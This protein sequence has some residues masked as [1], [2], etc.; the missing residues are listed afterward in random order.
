MDFLKNLLP[1]PAE[2]LVNSIFRDFYPGLFP[3]LDLDQLKNSLITTNNIKIET[4]SLDSTSINDWLLTS[5][6]LEVSSI[7]LKG[8]LFTFPRM[9]LT[10]KITLEI[11]VI[12]IVLKFKSKNYVFKSIEKPKENFL[13]QGINKALD[14]YGMLVKNINVVLIEEETNTLYFIKM[15]NIEYHNK[16]NS[17]NS[18]YCAYK[19]KIIE[20]K[21]NHPLNKNYLFFVGNHLTIESIIVEEIQLDDKSLLENRDQDLLTILE[22]SS[23]TEYI[24][25]KLK[26]KTIFESNYLL[27]LIKFLPECILNFDFQTNLVNLRV[28]YYFENKVKAYGS[29]QDL[30]LLDK[31]ISGFKFN[32]NIDNASLLI[33]NQPFHLNINN[34]DY[35]NYNAENIQL[36]YY[37]GDITLEAKKAYDS[38]FTIYDISIILLKNFYLKCLISEV[39]IKL[40]NYNIFKFDSLYNKSCF[41]TKEKIDNI[42]NNFDSQLKI[43]LFVNTTNINFTYQQL[44]SES[45]KHK[46]IRNSEFSQNTEIQIRLKIENL[47]IKKYSTLEINRKTNLI[48][49]DESQQISQPVIANIINIDFTSLTTSIEIQKYTNSKIFE[50]HNEFNNLTNIKNVN[51]ISSLLDKKQIWLFQQKIIIQ[52]SKNHIKKIKSNEENNVNH[53]LSENNIILLKTINIILSKSINLNL[54]KDSVNI[55]LLVS[56]EFKIKTLSK[57]LIELK[58]IKER[59][60]FKLSSIYDS[61][62]YNNYDKQ[63][64][65]SEKDLFFGKFNSLLF[66]KERKSSKDDFFLQNNQIIKVKCNVNNISLIVKHNLVFEIN[67]ILFSL[68]NNESSTLADLLIS[69]LSMHLNNKIFLSL[70]SN[71]SSHNTIRTIKSNNKINTEFKFSNLKIAIDNNLLK[72]VEHLRKYL[73]E[74]YSFNSYYEIKKTSFQLEN[75]ALSEESNYYYLSTDGLINILQSEISV[76]KDKQIRKY[77]V[78]KYNYDNTMNINNL[79]I[80]VTSSI[81]SNPSLSNEIRQVINIPNIK[82]I[83]KFN[84]KSIYKDFLLNIDYLNTFLL[85]N[86]DFEDSKTEQDSINCLSL[87]YFYIK[88][89]QFYMTENTNNEFFINSVNMN[90]CKDSLTYFTILN[91]SLIN[92]VALIINNCKSFN[93][94][95][96][97]ENLKNCE[98]FFDLLNNKNYIKENIVK[99]LLIKTNISQFDYFSF[100]LNH[101]NNYLLNTFFMIG[102]INLVFYQGYD[103]FFVKSCEFEVVSKSKKVNN[104]L[105]YTIIEDCIL[106][107]NGVKEK[108]EES[109]SIVFVDDKTNMDSNQLKFNKRVKVDNRDTNCFISFNINEVMINHHKI[110]DKETDIEIKNIDV[111]Y[112]NCN[113]VVI[114]E[115]INSNSKKKSLK[116][117][118]KYCLYKSSFIIKLFFA[119][120]DLSINLNS[121]IIEL[122][123]NYISFYET[124]TG[125][126]LLNYK[127]EKE[128]KNDKIEIVNSLNDECYNNIVSINNSGIMIDGMLIQED[129][130]LKYNKNRNL[131]KITNSKEENNKQVNY[132]DNNNRLNYFEYVGSFNIQEF[133][134]KLSYSQPKEMLNNLYSFN[135]FSIIFKEFTS[136]E[137]NLPILNTIL[138]KYFIHLRDDIINNQIV[139]AYLST[140][141]LIKPISRFISSGVR[142]FYYPNITKDDNERI[143]ARF[144]KGFKSIINLLKD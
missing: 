50:Y 116:L 86:L 136:K 15:K 48:K 14:N 27:L 144:K 43:D 91:K 76:I 20:N 137:L 40:S 72:G 88:S 39:D 3:N 122:I 4:M 89:K 113:K 7:S 78:N 134:L 8:F 19:D 58:K 44:T 73:L 83:F 79:S 61:L 71:E 49:F 110:K 54:T 81:N 124:T 45:I 139:E 90:F 105:N 56:Q 33:E 129:I 111:S 17:I 64:N 93:K 70:S 108:Q 133:K 97:E 57:E 126:K 9:Y 29:K 109:W 26:R 80:S 130:V 42:I 60:D 115:R 18:N 22:K 140:F 118:L 24:A 102:N 31:K 123:N 38:I 36:V 135:D 59:N 28:N 30:W 5:Y 128:G 119:L 51:E 94:K 68:C 10:T 120:D 75:G 142:L 95:A 32:F 98:L 103:F 47:I 84:Q 67:N 82:L 65:Y 52:Q 125:I 34:H 100:E 117:N 46:I 87:K 107:F 131:S 1:Y 2:E 106:E 127:H 121:E 114:L 35:N 69:N 112:N 132:K 12:D 138:K 55:I 11:D 143:L 62:L 77:K 63:V 37:E 13:S 74:D 92:E 96:K 66:P 104:N 141:Q 41:I 99:S 53:N 6:N 16:T 85:K 25:K 21:K 23:I 101:D